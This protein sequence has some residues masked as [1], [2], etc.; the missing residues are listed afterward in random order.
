LPH[1]EP[2]RL[3]DGRWPYLVAV[4]DLPSGYQL[5]WLP[6]LDQSAESTIDALQW[7]LPEHGPPLVLKSHNGSSFITDEMRRSLTAG[8]SGPSSHRRTRR[9][10][11]ALPR[12]ATAR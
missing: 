12:R 3:I 6:V 5:A 4:R 1:A 8:K 11:M 9:S 10:T 7:L 2:P